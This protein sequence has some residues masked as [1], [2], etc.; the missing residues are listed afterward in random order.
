M[1]RPTQAI[2][3]FHVFLL[4]ALFILMSSS[5]EFKEEIRLVKNQKLIPPTAFDL[6]E[7][8]A[9]GLDLTNV[10]NYKDV[11]IGDLYNE[12]ALLINGRVEYKNPN[13]N[14]I[15]K[16]HK[17]YLTETYPLSKFVT[18]QVY[19]SSG[20]VCG[21]TLYAVNTR[22]NSVEVVEGSIGE[23]EEFYP[24]SLFNYKLLGEYMMLKISKEHRDHYK[25]IPL[26]IKE[27]D[28]CIVNIEKLNVRSSPNSDNN[29]IGTLI[30]GTKVK[31]V[32]IIDDEWVKV[33]LKNG[34][35]YVASK[36]LQKEVVD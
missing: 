1:Y 34:D 3:R 8:G 26:P 6:I 10:S 2:K 11:T 23:D 24:G 4:F 29:L 21:I 28:I 33:A 27:N 13:L 32:E 35:G 17:E 9:Y 14:I 20:A 5:C 19:N 25:N 22:L 30:K 18:V 31:V 36:Y 12:I 16:A 15:K 7:L